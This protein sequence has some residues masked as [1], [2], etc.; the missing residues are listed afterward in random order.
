MERN[1]EKHEPRLIGD[2]IIE[3]AE[4]GEIMP[5]AKKLKE[6]YNG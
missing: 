3:L 6:E 2:I 5:Y 1:N 4:K